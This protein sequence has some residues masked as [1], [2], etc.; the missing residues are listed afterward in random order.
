MTSQPC[1]ACID[2]L[3]AYQVLA[4]AGISPPPKRVLNFITQRVKLDE[5]LGNGI[6]DI[7]G[8]A[9]V[10]ETGYHFCQF[11]RQHYF[12]Y[13]QKANPAT[14][15]SVQQWAQKRR[16]PVSVWATKGAVR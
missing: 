12:A 16:S 4:S 15:L 10:V 5:Y 11:H 8:C 3:D 6:T 9:E 1:E 2:A 14:M 13:R 7:C